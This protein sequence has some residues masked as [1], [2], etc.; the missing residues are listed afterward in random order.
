MSKMYSASI[1]EQLVHVLSELIAREPSRAAQSL[2]I[3]F[4][5]PKER[6]AQPAVSGSAG[7]L[8]PT[9]GGTLV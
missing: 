5:Q 7:V 9:N 8:V 1:H 3:V 4:S 6:R 2:Q